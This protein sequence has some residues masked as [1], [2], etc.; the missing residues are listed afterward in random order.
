LTMKSGLMARHSSSR[1]SCRSGRSIT[2]VYGRSK[3]SAHA[4]SGNSRYQSAGVEGSKRKRGSATGV[5]RKLPSARSPSLMPHRRVPVK[6]KSAIT[7]SNS[8]SSIALSAESALEANWM[9]PPKRANWP[10]F[11]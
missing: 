11:S 9:G 8:R 6:V 3:K 2:P 10:V 5:I 4:L 7:R 1:M